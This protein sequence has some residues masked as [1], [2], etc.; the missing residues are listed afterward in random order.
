LFF[1]GTGNNSSILEG[2]YSSEALQVFSREYPS[3]TPSYTFSRSV[4]P[5]SQ[6]KT[7]SSL[8]LTFSS[9]LE[10]LSERSTPSDDTLPHSNSNTVE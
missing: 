3:Y 1:L 6:N 5:T 4:C 2:E 8:L 10:T 7:A 9:E